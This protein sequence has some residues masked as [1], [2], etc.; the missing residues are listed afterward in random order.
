[1]E[2]MYAIICRKS[3]RDAPGGGRAALPVSRIASS[4]S[5]PMPCVRSPDI[6]QF[7]N[8]MDDVNGI[9][10]KWGRQ[11]IARPCT[12]IEMTAAS[13]HPDSA[14]PSFKVPAGEIE[15]RIRC[16]QGQ[17][18]DAGLDGIIVLQRV[19]LFYLSG[20]AQNGCLYLPAEGPP[21]LFIKQ[22]VPRARS[23]SPIEQ[24]IEIASIREVPKRIADACG[25]RPAKLGFELDVLPVNEFRF[26]QELFQPAECVDASPLI[27]GGRGLKSAWEIEQLR[28]TAVMSGRTFEYMREVIRPGMTEMEFAGLFEAYARGIGHGGKL[29]VR[30]HNTEGYTWHVLSGASG[31]LVGVLDSPASGAGT[32][33][34]F[35]A[36][37]GYKRLCVDEPIM[38]DFGSVMNGY[39]MDETRMFAIGRMPEP[40]LR[41]SRA[42]IDLHQAALENARPGITAGALFDLVE[43]MAGLMGLQDSFLGPPGRKVSFIGHGIGL[44]LIEPPIIARGRKTPLA[45]GMVLALEPKFVHENRFAAGIESVFEV[46]ENGGRLISTVPVDIFICDPG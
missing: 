25:R 41:I 13:T 28:S 46:T 38:V 18:Q 27:L 37:A 29:R 22:S 36:G 26:Y 44:E 20:T 12:G 45:A 39:H 5:I 1:M 35:P 8:G 23:E 6:F 15:R 33:S 10:K 34:A 31:G 30:H 40:A 11:A 32:S 17:L 21:L 7:P 3:N 4:R 9:Q 43:H 19:D 14:L 2:S 42:A 24:L 16:V